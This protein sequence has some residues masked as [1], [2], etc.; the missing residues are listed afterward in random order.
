MCFYLASN[1]ERYFSFCCCCSVVLLWFVSVFFIDWSCFWLS[2]NFHIQPFLFFKVCYFELVSVK[3]QRSS[4]DFSDHKI[5]KQVTEWR[6]FCHSP[7]PGSHGNIFY[8]WKYCSLWPL[9]YKT[10]INPWQLYAFSQHR[11]LLLT[12]LH[13]IQNRQ[14]VLLLSP[15][16]VVYFAFDSSKDGNCNDF[17]IWFWGASV[18][19]TFT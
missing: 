2:Q 14:T 7:C 10:V 11:L 6:S 1:I 4:I 12:R 16:L 8:G 19:N 3:I 15:T 17:I 13:S 9:H 18:H 5:L